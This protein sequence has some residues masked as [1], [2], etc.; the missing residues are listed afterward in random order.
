MKSDIRITCSFRTSLSFK[1]YCRR[2]WVSSCIFSF[3]V[4]SDSIRRFLFQVVEP[5]WRV[6]FDML[7]TYLCFDSCT[8]PLHEGTEPSCDSDQSRTGR[9]AIPLASTFWDLHTSCTL[10]WHAFSL[11]H[12][13]APCVASNF[14]CPAE[15]CV[16][17]MLLST[18]ALGE[19]RTTLP[20][21]SSRP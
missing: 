3:G 1:L 19:A 7:I 21:S 18:A 8:T 5:T 10:H 9:R 4:M 6:E 17:K 15:N 12:K 14:G 20:E 11:Q 13:H 16:T 2:F